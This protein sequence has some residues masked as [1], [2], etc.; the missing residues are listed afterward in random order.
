MSLSDPIADMLT[1]IRNAI[2]AKHETVK[3][4]SSNIKAEI[5]ALLRQE[6]YIKGFKIVRDNKQGMIH[7]LLKYKDDLSA[8]RGLKRI[9]KP[10]LRVYAGVEEIPEVLNGMGDA[11]LSTNKGILTDSEAREES[12]GGEVLCH[13][14]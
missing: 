2:M 5:A 4:P 11:I 1:R 13:I 9:S 6:G 8:I 14:W 7:I 3:I 10:G 12:V